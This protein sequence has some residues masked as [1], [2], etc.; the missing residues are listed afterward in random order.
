MHN[1]HNVHLH[2]LHVLYREAIQFYTSEV[3]KNKEQLQYDEQL[4]Y[5]VVD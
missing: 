1:V 3:K 5:L 4:P 2:V